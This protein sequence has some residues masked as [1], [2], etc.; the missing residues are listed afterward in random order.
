MLTSWKYI[1]QLFIFLTIKI[2]GLTMAYISCTVSKIDIGPLKLNN[3]LL[4]ATKTVK[5]IDAIVR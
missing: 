5:Y 2:S 4:G 3:Q 1:R